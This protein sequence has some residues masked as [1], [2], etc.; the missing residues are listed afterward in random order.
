[1]NGRDYAAFSS[2]VRRRRRRAVVGDISNLSVTLDGSTATLAFTDATGA[3]MHEYRWGVSSP[4][5]GA[6][7]LLGGTV[8]TSDMPAATEIF[9]QVRGRTV[10]S[11]GDASNVDSVTTA[12]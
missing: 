9:F 2:N 7:Q 12:P 8:D 10:A 4:P 3:T 11:A 6:W 1:M 5:A